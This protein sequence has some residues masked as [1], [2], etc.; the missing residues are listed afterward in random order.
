MRIGRVEVAG[1]VRFC[2]PVAG[3]VQLLSG[4]PAGGFEQD[5]D[6]LSEGEYRLLIPVQPDKVLVILGGFPRNQPVEEARKTPP[7]FA[8]KLP[9]SLIVH[10]DEVRMS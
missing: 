3:G 4:S 2:Q 9:S 7:R 1:E 10:G 6:R 8:A 5:R